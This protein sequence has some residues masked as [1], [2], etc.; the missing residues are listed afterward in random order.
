MVTNI[1]HTGMGD[2]EYTLKGN[3]PTILVMHGQSQDCNA[4]DGY[5]TFIKA[6]FSMLTPS[7]PG[8]GKTLASA[9]ES[10]E[11]AS[12][13]MVHLLDHLKIEKTHVMAVSG[14]GPTALFFAANHP[15]KIQKM[16]LVSAL[17]KL[18]Q[19]QARYETVKKFYGK[20]L[21]I[22]WLMLRVFSIV[23]PSLVARKTISLFSTHDPEDFLQHIS[24]QEIKTLLHLYKNKVYTKGPLIDLQCQPG[25]TVLHKI[26]VPT[27]VVHSKE[28]KSVDFEHAEYSVNNIKSAELFVSPTWSHFPWFGP[29]SEEE[30]E[31]VIGFLKKA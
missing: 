18:W 15:E 2:I 19:D 23:F 13:A 4:D 27:L 1:A 25:V 11:K 5:D 9:G 24:H 31:E 10:A 8:Y 12:E 28:D 30:L 26:E 21:P 29:H 3:G 17:S 14:G 20:S 22:V 7:R 16:I 6:G